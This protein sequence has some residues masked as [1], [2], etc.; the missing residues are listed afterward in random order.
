MSKKKKSS[1]RSRSRN[2]SRGKMKLR[3]H[4]KIKNAGP[5]LE[6][7]AAMLPQEMKNRIYGLVLGGN[8]LH[9]KRDLIKFKRD[10][11]HSTK[12]DIKERRF[13]H[14]ICCSQTS[15]EDAQHRFDAED[16]SSLYVKG[17]E[18][19]HSG[20]GPSKRKGSAYTPLRMDVNLLHACRQIYN[21]ARFM[22]YSTNT[23]SFHTPRNLR[24]FIHLLVQCGVNVN[25]AFRSLHVDIAHINHDLHGWG[26]AFNAVTQHMTLLEKVY[27]NVDQRPNWSICADAEQKEAAMRPVLDC[28]AI[29]GKTPA[30]STMIVVS[31]RHLSRMSDANLAGASTAWISCRWTV[32]EKKMWVEEVKLAIQD[33][34]FFG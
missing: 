6:T 32:E 28:L 15:E 31:D 34:Q 8:L 7:T 10:V 12:G 27:I 21:E 17:I 5:N 26:Q 29:L 18:L 16:G 2:Q 4:R 23:F 25:T 11:V 14:Q 20:C 1:T 30:K 24:T 9:I 3:S 19:R 33:T 13:T 22:P